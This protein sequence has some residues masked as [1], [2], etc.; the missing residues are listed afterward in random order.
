MWVMWLSPGTKETVYCP[1]SVCLI[2]ASVSLYLWRWNIRIK[3][4]TAVCSTIPSATRLNIWTSANS[5]T[6]VQVQQCWYVC[7]VTDLIFVLCCRSKLCI[8]FFMITAL[9]GHI[10]SQ[11]VSLIVLISAAAG[12]LLAAVRIFC[13]CRRNRKTDQEGKCY[14]I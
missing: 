14:S 1:A 7:L 10:T 8:H 11:T 3:T 13:I 2:S 6:H 9:D 4:P 12:S 5:V